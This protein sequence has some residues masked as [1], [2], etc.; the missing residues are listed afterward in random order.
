MPVHANTGSAVAPAPFATEARSVTA[1]QVAMIL[2]QTV[3][4]PISFDLLARAIRH[5]FAHP[6]CEP[7]LQAL[8]EALCQTS[9]TSLVEATDLRFGDLL[10][11]ARCLG[12]DGEKID[13]IEDMAGLEELA[14][15]LALDAREL[16]D[17][18]ADARADAQELAVDGGKAA[19]APAMGEA[20]D[21]PGDG[22]AVPGIA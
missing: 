10:D 13:W 4:K 1:R 9:L 5:P 19:S 18:A 17:A 8:F 14:D 3:G 21:D 22:L 20:A 2:G 15:E 6:A 11:L 12:L 16:A 7:H